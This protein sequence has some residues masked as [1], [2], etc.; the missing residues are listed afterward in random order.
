MNHI[1]K[2]RSGINLPLLYCWVKHVWYKFIPVFWAR[3]NDYHIHK[4][5]IHII[6]HRIWVFIEIYE[7]NFQT[8]CLAITCISRH[9]TRLWQNMKEMRSIVYIFLAYQYNMHSGSSQ[10]LSQ[11]VLNWILICLNYLI[12]IL[13]INITHI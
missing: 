13:F 2:L 9:K 7:Y 3:Q 5:Q 4:Q 10:E 12:A 11:W 6:Y 1:N 8:I